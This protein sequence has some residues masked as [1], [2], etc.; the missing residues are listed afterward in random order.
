MNLFVKSDEWTFFFFSR[1][2]SVKFVLAF[3]EIGYKKVNENII[4][5]TAFKPYSFNSGKKERCFITL[6]FYELW[7]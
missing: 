1:M 4:I 2:D 7:F 3:Q 5:Q 6:I